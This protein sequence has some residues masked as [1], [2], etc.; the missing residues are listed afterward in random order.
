MS[1]RADH[2]ERTA[3]FAMRA[4]GLTEANE[5]SIR[6]MW[7]DDFSVADIERA[8]HRSAPTIKAFAA[9]DPACVAHQR[10]GRTPSTMDALR[11]CRVR[12][13]PL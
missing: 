13:P 8:V 11:P 7:C 6:R 9:Q 10:A 3:V 5:K 2:A 4:N 1:R 12:G